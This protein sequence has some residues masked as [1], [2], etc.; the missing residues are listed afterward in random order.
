MV[1]KQFILLAAPQFT[2]SLPI[3]SVLAWILVF[4]FPSVLLD[5]VLVALNKQ[6]QDFFRTLGAAIFNV[7]LNIIWIPKYGV[8]GAAYASILSQALNTTVTFVYARSV[9]KKIQ[10]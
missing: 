6:K 2:L 3:V 7:I 1:L 9:L 10:D 5:N 8:L 4:M